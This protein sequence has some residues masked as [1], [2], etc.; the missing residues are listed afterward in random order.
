MV[1]FVNFVFSYS[2]TRS[3]SL[4]VPVPVNGL[5][6]SAFGCNI[7]FSPLHGNDRGVQ[8]QQRVAADKHVI[9]GMLGHSSAIVQIHL[10]Q[11][12]DALG[13]TTFTMDAM[14]RFCTLDTSASTSSDSLLPV[15]PA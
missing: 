5:I 14:F 3:L 6:N 7:P 10:L 11:V 1:R 8:Q 13:R 15:T 2:T 12:L 4:P 9:S